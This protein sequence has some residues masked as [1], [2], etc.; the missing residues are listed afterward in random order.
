M[1]GWFVTGLLLVWFLSSVTSVRA[2]ELFGVFNLRTRLFRQLHDA[3]EQVPVRT[4]HPIVLAHGICGFDRVKWGPVEVRYFN[5]IEAHLKAC[6][7]EVLTTEVPATGSILR[8]AEAL[9]R[10]IRAWQPGR[11]VNLI[12]HSMGGLDS[13]FM[14]SRLGMGA[15]VASL[16]M[17]GTPN[18]GTLLS[19]WA[20]YW[21][22]ER[23]PG[24]ERFLRALGIDTGG[25]RDLAVAHIVNEFNPRTP[26]DP[27]VSYRT[28]AGSQELRHYLPPLAATHL[29]LR[30]LEKTLAGQALSAAELAPVEALAKKHGVGFALSREG[31]RRMLRSLPSDW[32]VPSLVGKTDGLVSM[33][34]VRHGAYLGDLDADH[35]DEMGWLTTFDARGLYEAIARQ[36]A[37]TGY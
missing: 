18:H 34:S 30:G 19:D 3:P 15:R 22:A 33:S 17:I 32:L 36:L 8:R 5:R 29:V 16:T 26:D 28:L 14:I 24:V 7:F 12:A 37:E 23:V 11:K 13:R 6:G 31:F 2:G 21:G 20:V 27:R 4:R 1:R 10:Q 25:F 9:A 35:L